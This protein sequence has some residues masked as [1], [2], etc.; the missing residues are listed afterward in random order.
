MPNAMSSRES[1]GG[2]R[3]FFLYAV[4]TLGLVAVATV[5]AGGASETSLGLFLAWT[6]QLVAF[7]PLTTALAERRDMM[8]AWLGGLALRSAGL[9]AT[10]GLA[11]AGRTES[12]LP[13]AYGTG[14]MV[15]LLVEAGWLFRRLPRPEGLADGGVGTD[16][17]IERT[18][19]G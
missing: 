9:I 15:L 3:G 12:D 8:R 16:N 17:G 14:M 11:L 7:R 18:T 1:E 5:V 13:I 4:G 10:G 2:S 6:I 19:T